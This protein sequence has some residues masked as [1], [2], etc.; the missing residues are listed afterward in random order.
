M[1]FDIFTI[2]RRLPKAWSNTIC[3]IIGWIEEQFLKMPI[4]IAC[5]MSWTSPRMRENGNYWWFPA[6]WVGR[7]RQLEKPATKDGVKWRVYNA[8]F[9]F[10]GLF[11]GVGISWA[12]KEKQ[13]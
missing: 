7:N 3:D 11:F 10:L 9:D 5:E 1:R 4:I 13:L 6:L 2:T 12:G 8:G